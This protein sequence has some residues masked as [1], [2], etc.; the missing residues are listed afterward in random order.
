MT[1]TN[2]DADGVLAR[3]RKLLTKAE[4]P[5]A[6]AQEPEAYTAKASELMAAYGIDRALLAAADP[7]FDVVGDQVITLDPPYAAEN[8]Q[9]VVEVA[10]SLG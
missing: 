8:A 9:L 5:A 4:D 6:T 3:V 1:I 2:R 7:T 10:R